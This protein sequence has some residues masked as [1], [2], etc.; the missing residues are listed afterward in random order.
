[1]PPSDWRDKAAFMR[2]VGAVEATWHPIDTETFMLV[3]LKLAPVA[4]RPVATQPAALP[5]G[6]AAKLAESFAER[7]KRDHET[8][9]AASHFRPPMSVPKPADSDD[10]PRA[11]RVRE[12]S[13]GRP[14]KKQRRR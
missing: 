13:S 1:M 2:E 8:R 10:V 9:F 3:S 5:K 12:S 14:T 4:P 6:T 11:V 7:L